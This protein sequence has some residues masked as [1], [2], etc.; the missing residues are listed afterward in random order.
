LITTEVFLRGPDYKAI[1]VSVGIN[2]VAGASIAETTDAVKQELLK[3][4]SPL[5]PA[6][7]SQIEA[8]AALLTTPQ[9][10]ATQNGWTLGKAVASRE[11]LA[12][13][14]RVANVESV[15][16]VL[17]A[18]GAKSSAD[19]IPMTGLELPRVLGI[20]VGVGDPT[21]IDA[22][23]GTVKPKGA[24]G[25]GQSLIVPVPVIPEEC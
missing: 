6:G 24:G 18:E 2:V 19:K 11:L 16:D 23:R 15:N 7:R 1:W 22:L 13:A 4:L 21:P 10:A 20:S 3:F 12:V 8:E 5:P 17:V 14:S 9:F 25:G